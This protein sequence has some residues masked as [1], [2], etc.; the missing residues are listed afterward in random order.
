MSWLPKPKKK[1]ILNEGVNKALESLKIPFVDPPHP[2]SSTLGGNGDSSVS[3]DDAVEALNSY[4]LSDDSLANQSVFDGEHQTDDQEYFHLLDELGDC[5]EDGSILG[6][7]PSDDIED[8]CGPIFDAVTGKARASDE[9]LRAYAFSQTL[10]H[11]AIAACPSGNRGRCRFGGD[12]CGKMDVRDIWNMR[13]AFWNFD[14][15]NAPTTSQRNEQI[16]EKLKR[17][18]YIYI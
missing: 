10:C 13:S 7:A 8:D 17:N 6:D 12:C 14:M 5:D 16:T 18:I 3:T 4:L 9:D 1:I 15:A 2:G 11:L